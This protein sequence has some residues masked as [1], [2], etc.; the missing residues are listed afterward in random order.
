MHHAY[1][2]L[3]AIMQHL[4]NRSDCEVL[5]HHLFVIKF[6]PDNP[7]VNVIVNLLFKDGNFVVKSNKFLICLDNCLLGVWIV[8]DLRT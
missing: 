5:V 1:L 2:I 3:E 6:K 7:R 8:E 4:I